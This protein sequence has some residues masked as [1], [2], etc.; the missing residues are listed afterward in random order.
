M[1]GDAFFVASSKYMRSTGKIGLL[2]I[3]TAVVALAHPGLQFGLRDTEGVEHTP[4]EWAGAQAVV[5]FFVTT[6]CPLSNGYAPEMNRIQQTYTPRGVLFYA[7]QGDTTVPDG[8]VRRH[9]QEYGY[10]FPALLDPREILAHH[11]GAT[12]TPEAAVL[13]PTGA[14]LYLGRIDNKV[15]DFG[16][17]RLQATQFDLRE[18]LEAVLAGKPVPHPRTHALGCAI[19]AAAQAAPPTFNKDI[20]PILYKNCATC[21][22]PGE[23]A[24]FALL[25]Y[26]DAAKKAALLATV[27]ERRV[28]P[29]WKAEPGYGSFASERR[30]SDE[31]IA[32]IGDWAQS[33]APEGEA[34]DKPAAPVFASGWGAGQPDKVLTMSHKFEVAAD[35]PDQYRCFV[36]PLDTAQDV[37]LSSMEFRPGN[38]RVVHHA[39][40][41]ADATGTARRLAADS[42]DGSYTCFGG[43]KFPPAGLLGGW[44]PGASPPPD[45]PSLSQLIR[46]GTDVVV[47]IHYHPSGKPEEDQSSLGLKFSGP[48]TK[49]RAGIILSNRRIQI[50]AGDP[51]YVVKTAVTLPR[52]VDVFGITPHAHYI[53]KDMKVNAVL[54]DG[55]VQHL[56]WIKDWDFNWQGQYRY[57]EPVHLPRGT[58]IELEYVY[59]NSE[60]NPHNPSHPP[61]PVTFGEETRNEMAV[62]F[63]G[64]ELP[65]AEDV[66]AFRREMRTQYIESFLAEG[67]TLKD[68]P[69]E[70]PK[71]ELELI[72][73][74]FQTFDKNGDGKLDAEE[75][76]ALMQYL[77][78]MQH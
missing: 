13:S 36:L 8:E 4:Q 5:L 29:P 43:P 63:L 6:D 39:L 49:G 21:H 11:T 40:V 70:I 65:S 34:Q 72:K 7:V 45:S 75:R 48:P 38:R 60:N 54:P 18:A 3:L 71:G 68:L 67:N 76:A 62:L 27:T 55:T 77:H 44:A 56:I 58:R 41:Y 10:R 26:A 19:T 12:V 66:P 25:T 28:M 52:D 14:V 35:G 74:V 22:R 78:G 32:L 31:Q 69:P 2:A 33:G 61:V 51:H 50:S 42:A 17:T 9:A 16:K 46:K 15:E 57:K 24:P 20:A 23:V 30:L 1:C 37:Y 64:V 47:Q 73:R 59:D 53:G